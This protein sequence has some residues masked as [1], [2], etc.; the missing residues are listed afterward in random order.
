MLAA[1]IIVV[2]LGA[3]VTFLMF[4]QV[5]AMAAAHPIVALSIFAGLFVIEAELLFVASGSRRVRFSTSHNRLLR[6]T[7][8]TLRENEEKLAVTLNSIGDGVI[9]T[10]VEGRVTRL[11]PVAEAL[12]GWTLAD[13]LG[14]PVFEVFTVI[15]RESH[16]PPTIPMMQTLARGM[17]Q[18]LANHTVLIARDGS[19]RNITNSCAPIHGSEGQVVGAVLV[20]RNVTAEYAVQ[21]AMRDSAALVQAILNTVRGR[22]HHPP[23]QWRNEEMGHA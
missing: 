1:S 22:H 16:L 3:T 7:N 12:T 8:L 15:N 11:N 23:R 10:D 14:R 17:M 4:G 19:E 6:K 5:K 18:G 21:Q 2:A 9:A 20:F 13:A